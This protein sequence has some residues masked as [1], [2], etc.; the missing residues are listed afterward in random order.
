[1]AVITYVDV[2]EFMG[3]AADIQNTQQD[4]ITSLISN[5]ETQVE[6]MLGRKLTPLTVTNLILEHGLNCEI[7]GKYI[8]LKGVY[9]DIYTISSIY[10]N[11]ALLTAV[12]SYS[13]GGDYFLDAVAGKLIRRDQ[14]WSQEPFGIKL[15]GTACLGGATTPYVIKQALIELVAAKSGFWKQNVLTE[16]GEITT[17]RTTASKET[18]DQLKSYIMRG[19]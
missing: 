16:G 12:T 11:D 6:E 3:S 19:C 13:G 2:F 18:L 15:S 8:Y 1:M 17:I 9:R 4:F 10:E 14:D 7:Y 5:T